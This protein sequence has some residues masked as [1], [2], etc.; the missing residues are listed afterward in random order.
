MQYDQKILTIAADNGAV[1][2][3]LR[4]MTPNLQKTLQECGY[5]VTLIQVRVQVSHLAPVST[6]T[7][8]VLST[9]G[10]KQLSELADTLAD[11]PL[12]RALQGLLRRSKN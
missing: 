10:K 8:P 11:S 3:K 5:E 12:K 1:A 2:A 4:Q 7:K 6:P 9:G